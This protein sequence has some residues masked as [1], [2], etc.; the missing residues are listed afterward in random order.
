MESIGGAWIMFSA[1]SICQNGFIFLASAY[2]GFWY[3]FPFSGWL[4]N[5]VSSGSWHKHNMLIKQVIW[6]RTKKNE[7]MLQTMTKPLRL[8]IPIHNFPPQSITCHLFCQIHWLSTVFSS[9][10]S[11]RHP[12]SGDNVA[13]S[14]RSFYIL[15][16]IQLIKFMIWFSLVSSPPVQTPG[17]FIFSSDLSR[18]NQRFF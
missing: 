6:S 3:W 7:R 4:I 12:C 17:D 13:A 8:V 11:L 18:A 9:E 16:M 1:L 5:F 15:A 14:F 2:S 10:I